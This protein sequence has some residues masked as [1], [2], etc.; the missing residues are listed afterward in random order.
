M[1]GIGWRDVAQSAVV[2]GQRMITF[3]LEGNVRQLVTSCGPVGTRGCK[4]RAAP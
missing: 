4:W 3:S 1:R 2:G